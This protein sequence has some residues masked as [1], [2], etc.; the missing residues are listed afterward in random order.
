VT[1]LNGASLSVFWGLP[2]IGLLGSLASM[3]VLMPQLW[4]KYYGKIALLWTLTILIPLWAYF[5][6]NVT[7]HTIFETYVHHF[8]PFIIFILAFYTIC[9][10][11]KIDI[12]CR[13]T[14][15]F[16]TTYVAFATF[17]AN[18]IGTTGAAM[19]FIRPLLH[20][21]QHRDQKKHL[22]I[23]FIF[24]VC[25]IG[26]CL[27]P[28]GDPPLFLGF[29]NGVDFIWPFVHLMGPFLTTAT[30][31]L[32]VFYLFDRHFT[33]RE[34]KPLG[35]KPIVFKV[36]IL[37]GHN[38][39]FL[40]LAIAAIS[41][42]GVWKMTFNFH[43]FGMSVSLQGIIRDLF[44]IGLVF[45]SLWT[46]PSRIRKQNSFTWVPLK[47][48]AIIFA[49]IFITAAPLF[50]ILHAGSEGAFSGLLNLINNEG[51]PHNMLYYWLTGIMSSLLD[52]APTYLMFFNMAG[53][54]AESL[55]TTY[56]TTL[57]AI[58]LGAVFMGALTYIGNAPNFMVKAI[59][60]ENEIKMPSFL[61]YLKWSTVILI[62]IFIIIG[63][64]WL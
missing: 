15:M 51:Q 44:L 45:L 1:Y 49:A 37:G 55:M 11:I 16:N 24:L 32:F 41:L 21:N 18:W 29:L 58:S 20:I 36:K 4:H 48:V 63:W 40:G 42:S 38:I 27:T 64:L 47:E 53:G 28:L 59:A 22:V 6:L 60:E 31:L 12:S 19:L 3:P 43:V 9:G 62:P 39:L 33:S 30:P 54:D 25:N 35:D 34:I 46:T 8:F 23:F 17:L 61:G 2:F 56:A 26:G 13:A 7:L 57:T 5:G 52:N 14:P 50:A 10:G